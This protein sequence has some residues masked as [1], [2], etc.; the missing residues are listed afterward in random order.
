VNCVNC[1]REI[2]D[3][4]NFCPYCGTTQPAAGSTPSAGAPL[5]PPAPMGGVRSNPQPAG[6]F[7]QSGVPGGAAVPGASQRATMAMILGIASLVVTFLCCWCYGLGGLVGSGLGITAFV[8]GRN[9]LEDIAGGFASPAGQS[10]ANLGK[11]LGLI[12]A[13]LGA[14]AFL[15]MLGMIVLGAIMGAAGN[16]SGYNY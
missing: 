10:N 11:T 2:S 14:L 5:P 15:M 13:I 4:S 6:T 7:S 9:E 12:G 1:R 16:S 3:G 8:M